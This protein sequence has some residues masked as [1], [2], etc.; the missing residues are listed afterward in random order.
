[1]WSVLIH[2]FIHS[3]IPKYYA[4]STKYTKIKTEPRLGFH[5]ARLSRAWGIGI[6]K[7]HI[8]IML[9]QK[10]IHFMQAQHQDCSATNNI[11]VPLADFSHIC[12][13]KPTV[14]YSL[15]TNFPFFILSLSL[16]ESGFFW[17]IPSLFWTFLQLLYLNP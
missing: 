12:C 4:P 17:N 9:S 5:T 6:A 7:I 13:L 2:S 16:S 14:S 3:F 1:M 11:N 15:Y 8:P 10:L